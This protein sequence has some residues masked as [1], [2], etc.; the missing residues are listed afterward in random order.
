MIY[1][2][3]NDD[4]KILKLCFSFQNTIIDIIKNELKIIIKNF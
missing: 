2:I 3:Y 4:F 1:I